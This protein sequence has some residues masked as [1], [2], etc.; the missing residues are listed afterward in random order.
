M[1]EI[2]LGTP[3]AQLDE[4]T[5]VELDACRAIVLPP[6]A[7]RPTRRKPRKAWTASPHGYGIIYQWEHGVTDLGWAAGDRS[8]SDVVEAHRGVR[9]RRAFALPPGQAI[10]GVPPAYARARRVLV[11]GGGLAAAVAAFVGYTHYR[12]IGAP[13]GMH[14]ATF[15]LVVALL[16]IAFLMLVLFPSSMPGYECQGRRLTLGEIALPR[17]SGEV[18]QRQVD[19]IKE[20]YGQLLSDLAYRIEYPALFDAACPLTEELTMALFEWDSTAACV[21]SIARDQLASRIVS[22]FEQAKEHAER[23]GLSHLPEE[24]RDTATRALG[25]VRLAQ[26]STATAAERESGLRTAVRLLDAIALYY[27]PTPGQVRDAIAGRRIR[28]LPGRRQP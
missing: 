3:L 26:D 9:V 14:I 22:A 5:L 2:S 21:D 19:D 4:P 8:I 27:L 18:A 10:I 7:P 12:A 24:Y 20:R 17:G 28:C 1:R 15:A 11:W 6:H 23:V 13:W 25:A 16:G